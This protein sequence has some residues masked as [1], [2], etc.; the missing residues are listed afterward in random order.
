MITVSKKESIGIEEKEED[1]LSIYSKDGRESMLDDDE[2][3]PVEEAF[4][5]GYEDAI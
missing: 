1:D 2:L 5:S 4:M 3:T